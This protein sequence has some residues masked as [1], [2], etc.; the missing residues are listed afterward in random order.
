MIA[1][2]RPFQTRKS[3]HIRHDRPLLSRR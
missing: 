2:Y 3:G 1:Q